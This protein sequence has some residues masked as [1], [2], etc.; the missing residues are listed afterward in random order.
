[1]IVNKIV[2]Y[3]LN[4]Y[5]L[6]D[7]EPWDFSGLIFDIFLNDEIKNIAISLDINNNIIDNCIKNNI[8]L[9]ITHHP[10]YICDKEN[11]YEFKQN[12]YYKN[13]LKK[14]F[15]NRI[16]VLSLHTNYDINEKGL[17]YNLIKLL[18]LSNIKQINNGYGF[19]GKTNKSLLEL[20]KTL[21]SDYF[22]SNK[23]DFNKKTNTIYIGGGACSSEIEKNIDDKNIDAFISSEIKWHLYV[24]ANDLNKT[25]IDVG[26]NVESIIC[27]SIKSELEKKF[28]VDIKI[29]DKIKLFSI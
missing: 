5:K 11:E 19:I 16:T 2:D 9:L 4:K 24:K 25:L 20:K 23:M 29:I 3:L 12:K 28:D 21:N 1:M 18:E 6:E 17:N 22:I 8:N 26:H 15:D 14:I 7:Q 13:I 10:L 27:N